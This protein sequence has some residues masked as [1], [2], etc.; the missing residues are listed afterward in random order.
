[1]LYSV[2]KHE[3]VDVE[4]VLSLCNEQASSWRRLEGEFLKLLGECAVEMYVKELCR[5]C[6]IAIDNRRALGDTVIDLKSQKRLCPG[7]LYLSFSDALSRVLRKGEV[8]NLDLF[9]IRLLISSYARPTIMSE[10]GFRRLQLLRDL[11]LIDWHFGC[12]DLLRVDMLEALK[13]DIFKDIKPDVENTL[14]IWSSEV[15]GCKDLVLFEDVDVTDAMLNTDVVCM[16][17]SKSHYVGE[18][19][20]TVRL[21]PSRCLDLSAWLEL[22]NRPLC[23]D[24]IIELGRINITVDVNV[25]QPTKVVAIVA[26]ASETEPTPNPGLL[27]EAEHKLAKLK[28][29]NAPVEG[30]LLYV[31]HGKNAKKT[32]VKLYRIA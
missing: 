15:R 24:L 21:R 22:P 27:T 2:V 18:L 9:P 28:N 14:K 23:E 10:Q 17:L 11:P 20:V 32:Q 29:L 6:D 7:D 31:F 26:R 4:H 3:E 16:N 12:C 25:G 13:D 1:V 19:P 8:F 5:E 30:Y